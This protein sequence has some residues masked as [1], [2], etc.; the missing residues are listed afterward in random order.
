MLSKTSPVRIQ[1][2]VPGNVL[3]MAAS[4]GTPQSKN[5][6]LL[7]GGKAYTKIDLRGEDVT[8]TQV[9]NKPTYTIVEGTFQSFS[10]RSGKNVT[11]TV[12][13]KFP[14]GTTFRI[15]Q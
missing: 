7:D 12:R 4:R 13:K 6:S 15:L 5:W 2:V 1:H 10:G 9:T 14:K 3:H 8:I 11:R